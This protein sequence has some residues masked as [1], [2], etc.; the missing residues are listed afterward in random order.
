M[1][2]ILHSRTLAGLA[3]FVSSALGLVSCASE[4]T[5]TGSSPAFV[6]IE[7]LQ[8]ASGA[9][10]DEFGSPVSSDVVTKGSVFNDLGQARMSLGLRN[11]GTSA[12]PTAPTSLNQ[13]TLHRYRVNFR[14]ADGRNTP[15]VDVPHSFDGA[16][17]MTVPATGNVTFGFE[18]VRVQAKLEP[19]LANLAGFSGGRVVISTLAEITF[20]GRDQAGNEVEATGTLQ[21]NFSDFADPEEEE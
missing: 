4:L 1:R 15:G 2:S 7:S 8:G 18:L 3:V 13:I 14:R 20:Y 12:N 5:R 10:P 6:I 19:P 17:T 11:P 9:T 21:V 16:I